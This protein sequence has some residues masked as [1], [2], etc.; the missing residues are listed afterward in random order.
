M[1]NEAELIEPDPK[2]AEKW[3][4]LSMRQAKIYTITKTF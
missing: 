1:T 2:V 4:D 3:E